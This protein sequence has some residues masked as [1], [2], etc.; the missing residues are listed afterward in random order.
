MRHGLIAVVLAAVGCLNSIT[1]AQD[2]L[3]GTW[4]LTLRDDGIS[5]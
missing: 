2:D 4:R 3:A 1:M 5:I